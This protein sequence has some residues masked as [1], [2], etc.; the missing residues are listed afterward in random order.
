MG[1][2]GSSQACWSSTPP[3]EQSPFVHSLRRQPVFDRRSL[4]RRC[5]MALDGSAL[6]VRLRQQEPQLADTDALELA[7]AIQRGALVLFTD[8]PT[9]AQTDPH[10][11]PSSVG[12]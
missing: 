5:R 3:T 10:P 4:N 9:L 8:Q 2:Q 1:L 12:F 6:A 7:T 11:V